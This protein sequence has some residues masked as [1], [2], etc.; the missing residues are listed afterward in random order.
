MKLSWHIRRI[1]DENGEDSGFCFVRGHLTK[2]ATSQ[3]HALSA[4]HRM[5]GLCSYGIFPLLHETNSDARQPYDPEDGWKR[6]YVEPLEAWAHCFREPDRYLPPGRPRELFSN[7]DFTDADKVWSMGMQ[8]NRPAKRWDLVYVCY[9]N[10]FHDVTKNWP[11]ARRCLAPLSKAGLR[12]LIVGRADFP[13]IPDLP[14]IETIGRLGQDEFLQCVARARVLWVPSGLDPSPRVIPEALSL[15]V[16]VLAYEHL[17]GGWKYVT[18]E[19]GAFFHDEGDVASA[20]V[21]LLS[22]SL[23]P[24]KWFTENFGRPRAE[25]RLAGLLRS[26]GPDP[27]GRSGSSQARRARIA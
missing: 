21:A 2:E 11:L 9:G 22:R 15:D 13:D 26:L 25:E 4:D 5:L 10:W 27:S 7:S 3:F 20:A 16:P 14:G 24:R 18:P 8:G 1:V 17:L 6:P 23:E 19:T 12:V